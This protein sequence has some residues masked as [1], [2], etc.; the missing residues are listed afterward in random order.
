[1]SE[2]RS[3][4]DLP[5][6]F[7]EIVPSDT[8]TLFDAFDRAGKRA[9][10]YY[11]P[12]LTCYH[13][14]PGRRVLVGTYESLLF[15]LA[16]TDRKRVVYNLL[17]PPIPFDPGTMTR[18]CDSL[19]ELTDLDPRVLWC[20]SE[21]AETARSAGY[22][23][24]EKELEYCYDPSRISAME[25]SEYKTLRKRVRQIEARLQPEC[26]ALETDDLADCRDL[27]KKWRRIQGRKQPFLLDWG[28][29]NAALDRFGD[30]GVQD[31]DGWCV[32]VSGRLAG[33]AM[34][35][36]MTS[37]QAS[38]FVAKTDPEFPGLSAFLRL[39]VYRALA[40]YRRVNDAGDLGLDGLRQHKQMFRPVEL[41]RVYS[42][43]R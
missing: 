37:D 19:R 20:D 31:L 41:R 17:V 3:V 24:E 21:D 15:I 18:M 2:A 22:E 4:D 29:T 38:F 33:F 14:P 39:H 11:A 35:G 13:L 5:G 36:R 34:A 10:C 7:H 1:M 6:S 26:R 16:R 40:D 27:M 28:Y 9:W 30:W 42:L 12:F 8:P 25:G 43:S 32:T 23:V